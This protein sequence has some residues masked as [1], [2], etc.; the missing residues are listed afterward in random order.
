MAEKA[1]D[2]TDEERGRLETIAYEISMVSKASQLVLLAEVQK[3][4]ALEAHLLHVRNALEF[5]GPSKDGSN[6]WA[7]DYAEGWPT[8]EAK[9]AYRDLKISAESGPQP[10]LDRLN[11]RLAH[12]DPERGKLDGSW[13][14]VFHVQKIAQLTRIFMAKTR[15][16]YRPELLRLFRNMGMEVP[17]EAEAN[18]TK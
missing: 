10:L 18:E 7:G 13:N 17:D 1:R 6:L 5:Y 4:A 9:D 8:N 2:F 12:M 3:V 14:H 15:P 16:E 11:K